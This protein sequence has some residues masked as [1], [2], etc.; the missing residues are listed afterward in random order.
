MRTQST[1]SQKANGVDLATKVSRCQKPQSL[2]TYYIEPE[3]EQI[4]FWS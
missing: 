1:Q 2:I 4:A 3:D